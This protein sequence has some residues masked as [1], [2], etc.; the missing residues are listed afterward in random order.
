V[1]SWCSRRLVGLLTLL[2]F[3]FGA[4]GSARAADPL[5]WGRPKVVDGR[6]LASVSCPTAS[7][8]VAL[9]S[10]GYVVTT[11]DPNGGASAWSSSSSR[12][13]TSA[14]LYGLSCPSSSLCVAV[15]GGSGEADVAT[16]TDPAGGSATWRES[17]LSGGNQLSA[18]SC[19]SVS[20]CV[21]VGYG[22]TLAT[23]TD[24][25]GGAGTWRV[26]QAPTSVPFE[27][28]K[29]GPEEDCQA[30]FTA[31]SCASVSL[32]VAVDSADNSLGDAVTSSDPAGAPTAWS[33]TPID[34]HTGLTGVA[35]PTVSLCVATGFDGRV[36]ASTTP[37]GSAASWVT[38]YE[39]GGELSAVSC[40]STSLCVEAASTCCNLG[41]PSLT[42]G[43]VATSVEP[44]G[45]A[46]AWTKSEIAPN[47]PSGLGAVSCVSSRMCVAV[48]GDGTA[49]VGTSPTRGQIKKFLRTQ[50][51]PP[52]GKRRLAAL[53]RRGGDRL[54]IRAIGAGRLQISWSADRLRN[55]RRRRVLVATASATFDRTGTIA[56]NVKLTRAGKRLLGH[57]TR[58]EVTAKARFTPIGR[59][60]VVVAKRFALG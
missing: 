36:L 7:L 47:A 13:N 23:S 49:V 4:A 26:T 3:G 21:A 48:G 18:V 22:G 44:L 56:V 1:R 46:T 29:Y 14:G 5:L 16:S 40:G 27:C 45:G 19:P 59:A 52:R 28:G 9:D 55:R 32:C 17:T 31:V 11:T 50:I 43:I 12:I 8:C 42:A 30:D 54:G 38:E 20:L 24:P 6:G 39:S 37:T 41:S 53:L 25:A 2:V 60:P 10:T 58:V 15:G 33:A 51:T 57:S 34:K 35:C